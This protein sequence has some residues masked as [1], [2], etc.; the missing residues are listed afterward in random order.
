MRIDQDAII[1]RQ[2]NLARYGTI[3]GTSAVEGSMRDGY[4]ATKS[5][6]AITNAPIQNTDPSSPDYG[7]FYFMIDYDPMP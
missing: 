6:P 1:K 3:I 5:L 2:I 4:G 7:K